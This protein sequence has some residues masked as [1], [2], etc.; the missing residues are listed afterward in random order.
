MRLDH[1]VLCFF[2]VFFPTSSGWALVVMGLVLDGRGPR[3]GRISARPA[4][5]LFLRFDLRELDCKVGW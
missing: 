5:Y 3:F 1:G 2:S 4:C